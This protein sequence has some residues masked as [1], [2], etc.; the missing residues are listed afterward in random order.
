MPREYRRSYGT[1]VLKGNLVINPIT[2][3]N[4]SNA[5]NMEDAAKYGIGWANGVDIR[6]PSVNYGIYPIVIHKGYSNASVSGTG[7]EGPLICESVKAVSLSV[8]GYK[9]R[10]SDTDNYG[11]L[12]QYCYEMPTPYFGDIG[13]GTTDENGECYISIDDKFSET[14]SDCRYYV[15][16]QKEGM[17]DVWIEKKEKNYFIVKG[18]PNV[19]F[20]WE[21][22]QKQKG[23]ENYRLDVVDEHLET[24][25]QPLNINKI[26]QDELMDMEDFYEQQY[27][28][29]GN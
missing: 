8:E 23:Y 7:I 16:L 11:K 20:S 21:V 25:V 4:D 5:S 27:Y 22:K 19:A 14:C 9:S 12:H 26:Y 24:E 6:D 17:G 29:Q 15:F 2:T 28:L 3:A 10:I 13:S 1:A 18:T